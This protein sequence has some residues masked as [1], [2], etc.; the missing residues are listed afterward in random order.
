M[1]GA[2]ETTLAQSGGVAPGDRVGIAMGNYPEWV[3]CSVRSPRPVSGM[4]ARRRHSDRTR[5]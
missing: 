4:V 3:V 1:A 2:L 5:A